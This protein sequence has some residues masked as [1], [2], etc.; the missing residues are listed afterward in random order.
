MNDEEEVGGEDEERE[1]GGVRPPLPPFLLTCPHDGCGMETFCSPCDNTMVALAVKFICPDEQ[2]ARKR[3]AME[4]SEVSRRAD[5]FDEK[6]TKVAWERVGRP[7]LERLEGALET[8]KRKVGGGSKGSKWDHWIDKWP[9][10]VSAVIFVVTTSSASL[11]FATWSD[12]D[13]A[14]GVLLFFASLSI[15][16]ALAILL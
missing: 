11:R 5:A 8:K 14:V 1:Q 3:E 12:G 10:K 7:L 16:I 15:G 2:A 6:A 13:P 4:I 9:L